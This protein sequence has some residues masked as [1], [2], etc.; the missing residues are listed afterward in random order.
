MLKEKIEAT[1]ALV[2]IELDHR[3]NELVALDLV[4]RSFW[5]LLEFKLHFLTFMQVGDHTIKPCE[6]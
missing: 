1:E 4:R 3:R 2:A 6:H 5:S